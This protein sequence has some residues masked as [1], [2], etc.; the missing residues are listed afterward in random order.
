ML[1]KLKNKSLAIQQ[2]NDTV[3]TTRYLKSNMLKN[4][5]IVNKYSAIIQ[6]VLNY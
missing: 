1:I 4:K 3:R 5:K 6:K 2:K